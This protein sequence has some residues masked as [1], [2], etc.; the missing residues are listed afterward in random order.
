MR[1]R[2]NLPFRVLSR[3]ATAG[4]GLVVLISMFGVNGC[5]SYKL[6]GVYVEP[7]AGA[8]ISPGATAQYTAYG[9]YTESGHATKTQNISDQVTWASDIPWLASISSS[10]LVTATTEGIGTTYISASA[11][12][13]F[14]TVWGDAPFTVGTNCV[15]SSTSSPAVF[16]GV[17]ILPGDQN[18][19]SIGDTTQL[20]PVGHYPSAPWSRDLSQQAKWTSSNP[21]VAT[22]A[23]DGLVTAVNAGKATVTATQTNERGEVVT[24]TIKVTVG[25]SSTNQ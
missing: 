25:S 10:G 15:P 13:E 2:S 12:G 20:V 17:R 16:T 9:T 8:C 1:F 21:E 24:A 6:T 3:P 19:L 4:L 14:G 23:P 5:V 7:S 11:P 18:L 22:V